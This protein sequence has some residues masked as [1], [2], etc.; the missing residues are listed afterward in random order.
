MTRWY[1]AQL[2]E[3]WR[4]SLEYLKKQ[5]TF[6]VLLCSF[7]SWLL[8]LLF[9]YKWSFRWWDSI[10]AFCSSNISHDTRVKTGLFNVALLANPLCSRLFRFNHQLPHG[11]VGVPK[12][13]IA[14]SGI[15]KNGTT[16]F[17]MRI[18]IRYCFEINVTFDIVEI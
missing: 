12:F 14:K 18:W 6:F 4:H 15:S 2:G 5:K 8:L 10:T 13:G 9:I 17:D 11:R 16:W 7:L 1:K 3:D